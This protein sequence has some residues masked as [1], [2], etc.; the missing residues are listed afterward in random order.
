[1]PEDVLTGSSSGT[2]FSGAKLSRGPA[3]DRLQDQISDLERFLVH[4]F[5]RGALWL[6]SKVEGMPWEYKKKKA[7]KFEEGEPK[8]KNFKLMA[9][10]TVEINFPISE[11]GDLEAKARALLGVKHG[12][13]TEQLGMS[14]T[15]VASHLGFQ[16]YNQSR[17]D[18]ATEED[19]Y[20]EL[21]TAA[22]IEAGQET[23]DAEGKVV[24]PT[25]PPPPGEETE[26]V[27]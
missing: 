13:V 27:E 8:F 1:M 21:K 10:K 3:S 22:E 17:L 12:P 14:M 5:W 2:K 24:P 26:P 11:M 18:A 6:H 19:T 15:E 7:Y 20:P 4:G 16:N 9:H 23:G 25:E